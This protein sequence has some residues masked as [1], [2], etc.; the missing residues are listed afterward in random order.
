M[1]AQLAA[2]AYQSPSQWGYVLAGWAI[3]GGLF[4]GYAASLLWRG[5]R[6]ARQVPP[7]ERRWMS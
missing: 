2:Q 7:E 1:I 3:V 6:L 4:A 5:R